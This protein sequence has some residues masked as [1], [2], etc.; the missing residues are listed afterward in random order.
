MEMIVAGALFL[1][2][3]IPTT[4]QPTPAVNSPTLHEIAKNVS[5]SKPPVKEIQITTEPTKEPEKEKVE[6]KTEVKKEPKLHEIKAG[7]T[8]NEIA[9]NYYGSGKFWTTLWNDNPEIKD[10][11][12]I[13]A[14]IKLKIREEKPEKEEELKEELAKIYEEINAPTPSISPK[15][16]V[17][18]TSVSSSPTPTTT[19]IQGPPSNFD[20]A[21]RQAGSRFGVPWE[22][23]YGLHHMETGGRDGAISSGYGTGAQGPLQFMPGTW[24]SYGIDGNADGTV[25]INNA[26]DA[27]YGAANYL[28]AHGGVDSGLRAYGGDS[29]KAKAYARSRGWNQ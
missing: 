10:P 15:K 6:V 16:E 4:A 14:G 12:I 24:A 9:E 28:A 23:L 17:A 22:I 8:L 7:E 1:I 20:E 27:I 26:V 29:E 5:Y 19:V 11:R 21:Y 25:D 3:L 2:N 18:G 13:N